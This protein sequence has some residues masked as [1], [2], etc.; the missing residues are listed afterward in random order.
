[1]YM[2][3]D[4]IVKNT[5]FVDLIVVKVKKFEL[6]EYEPRNILLPLSSTSD[7][8]ILESVR[9]VATNSRIDGNLTSGKELKFKASE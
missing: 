5:M 3:Y 6:F 1:M 9:S 2:A 4:H 7:R 8:K